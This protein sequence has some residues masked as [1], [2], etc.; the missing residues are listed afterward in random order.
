MRHLIT[1]QHV[2]I[3]QDFLS[4]ISISYI[5]FVSVCVRLW[6]ARKNQ[7]ISRALVVES[8]RVGTV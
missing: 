8:V 7:A 4:A 2:R 3:P 6:S 5:V 1:K